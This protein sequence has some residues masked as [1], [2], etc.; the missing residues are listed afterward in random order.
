VVL[1]SKGPMQS[2]WFMMRTWISCLFMFGLTRIP[3]RLCNIEDRSGLRD[4]SC[5]AA[6]I[7]GPAI[8]GRIIAM[9]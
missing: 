7:S 3:R 1:L 9:N 4:V 6:Q 2:N 8:Y 5:I